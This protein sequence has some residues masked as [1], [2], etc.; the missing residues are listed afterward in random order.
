MNSNDHLI[1]P[2]SWFIVLGLNMFIL[3]LRL[4][5][6]LEFGINLETKTR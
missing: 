2:N 5:N 3:D 4:V 6:F 1:G